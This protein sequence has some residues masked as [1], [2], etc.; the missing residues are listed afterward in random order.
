MKRNREA[1]GGETD[2]QW[3]FHLG[4]C[5]FDLQ[6][7]LQINAPPRGK[8]KIPMTLNLYTL[9]WRRLNKLCTKMVGGVGGP[10]LNS[11]SVIHFQTNA[12]TKRAG[13]ASPQSA[14]PAPAAAVISF[15]LENSRTQKG[16]T[17]IWK[18][19]YIMLKTV[20]QYWRLCHVNLNVKH[21]LVNLLNLMKLRQSRKIYLFFI[22]H[23]TL[24]FCLLWKG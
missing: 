20:I 15:Y 10:I 11:E 1:R 2:Q 17:H 4:V 8:S 22:S 7:E 12:E 5:G 21:T 9:R 14:A 3:L 23:L 18:S 16:C 6:T 13:N 19:K 24:N